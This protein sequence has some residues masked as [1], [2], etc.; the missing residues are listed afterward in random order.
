MRAAALVA[1]LLRTASVAR[2]AEP[3]AVHGGGSLKTDDVHQ[4]TVTY[5]GSAKVVLNPERGFRLE[6]DQ[7]CNS[8][9]TADAQWSK[10]MAAAAKY[11]IT[12][13]QTYCYLSTEETTVPVQL[14][15]QKLDQVRGVTF[16]F[17]CNYSRN[18]GL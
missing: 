2:A 18:T 14:S 12:V 8:G 6:L 1:L 3:R 17:L 9:P 11:N 16:S 4:Q 5:K 7:G 15:K 10:T 13:I